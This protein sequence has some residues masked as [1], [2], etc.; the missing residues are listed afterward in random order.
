MPAPCNDQ[1]KPLEELRP[2]VHITDEDLAKLYRA[3]DDDQGLGTEQ[4]LAKS[5]QRLYKRWPFR[6][7]MV[8]V[9]VAP[10]GG[11]LVEIVIAT[12][13]IS[14]HGMSGFHTAFAHPGTRVILELMRLDDQIERIPGSI[15]RCIHRKGTIHELG[16]QFAKEIDVAKFANEIAVMERFAM[17]RVDAEKLRGCLVHADPS[18]VDRALLAKML[19]ETMLRIRT[20][21]TVDETVELVREKA[22]VLVCE[23]HLI[24]GNALEVLEQ[25]R[26]GGSYVPMIVVTADNSAKIQ[27]ELE[28]S[29][30]DKILSKPC[31]QD[32]LLRSIAGFMLTPHGSGDRASTLKKGEPGYDLLPKYVQSLHAQAEEIERFI[33]TADMSGCVEQ[34]LRIKGSAPSLGFASLGSL[35][36]EAYRLTAGDGE[37]NRATVAALRRLAAACKAAEASSG[38]SSTD[39]ESQAGDAA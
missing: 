26:G 1:S 37:L 39:P 27:R 13:D 29:A 3:A 36:A 38:A 2:R 21:E 33:D 5:S 25:I 22:N 34:C 31:R 17:E 6:E 14:A 23:Y 19:N 12:L 8:R 32:A 20:A 16:I 15:V 10:P 11:G 9:H 7:R 28:Q 18:Q 30:V 4:N 35:A 24:G